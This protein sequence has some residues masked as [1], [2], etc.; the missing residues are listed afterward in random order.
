MS[1][2]FKTGS[3]AKAFNASCYLKYNALSGT[4]PGEFGT[5]FVAPSTWY[6]TQF[7]TMY[8]VDP[9]P[10]EGLSIVIPDAN[11]NNVGKTLSFRKPRLTSDVSP[12]MLSTPGGQNVGPTSA[13]VLYSPG[14]SCQIV[15]NPFEFAN[16]KGYKWRQSWEKAVDNNI[17]YVDKNLN[18]GFTSVAQAL[19]A[20]GTR[21]EYT[22][23]YVIRVGSGVFFEDTMQVPSYVSIIGVSPVNTTIVSKN[24]NDIFQLEG[25][26]EISQMTL[27]GATNFMQAAIRY[28]EEDAPHGQAVLDNC[29]LINNYHAFC[30]IN[31][32]QPST[33]Y[34]K[35]CEIY[36]TYVT[37][38]HI[39]SNDGYII[40]HID[41]LNVAMMSGDIV[42]QSVF[43]AMGSATQIDIYNTQIRNEFTQ[44][45][46]NAG[47]TFYDGAN[48]RAFNT[49]FEN[50]GV[51]I[52]GAYLG[53][54]SLIECSN[55]TI[56]GALVP[57]VIDHP[58]NI[59]SI[60][61]VFT[62]TISNVSPYMTFS[63][64]VPGGGRK[65]VIGGILYQRD[66]VT[67]PLIPISTLLRD[68]V[69]LGIISGGN[70]LQNDTL[71]VGVS[72]GMGYI[73]NTD[74]NT[75]DRVFWSD[76]IIPLSINSINYIVY[77]PISQVI[78]SIASRPDLVNEILFGR[79]VVGNSSI[80]H[81]EDQSLNILH[82]VTKNQEALRN[83]LG[84]IYSYGSN[85]TDNGNLTLNTSKGSYYYGFNEYILSGGSNIV[86]DTYFTDA[87][88]NYTEYAQDMAVIDN[89]N[90]NNVAGGVLSA[91]NTGYWTKH[92]I[93]ALG[94]IA[95]EYFMLYGNSQH[96][97]S[98]D[99]IGSTLPITPTF[100]DEMFVPIASLT[101][102]Q[103]SSAI[104]IADIRPRIGAIEILSSQ[105]TGSGVTVHAALQGLLADDHPQYLL[106]NGTRSMA[107]SLD[108][109][110][111]SITNIN[112]I[113]GIDAKHHASRHLPGG[114]D[115]ETFGPPSTIGTSNQ[116]GV[117]PAF[118]QQDHIHDH[119][120][121]SR[122]DMHALVTTNTHGFM[123]S[124]DKN[125]LTVL[126]ITSAANADVDTVV[127]SNSAN[128]ISDYNT[129][130]ALSAGWVGGNNVF[131][132]V[133]ANSAL[134]MSDNSTVNN[135]SAGWELT[136]TAVNTN[137]ASWTS[138]DSVYSTVN[139]TSALWTAD[140][141]VVVT[142]SATWNND[143]NT[144]NALS[145]SW[146]GGNSVYSTVNTTSALW[147]ADYNSMNSLSAG[148]E[149][150]RTTVNTTSATW[151]NDHNTLNTLSGSWTGGNSAFSTVNA[152]SALWVADYNSM[153]SLSGGWELARTTINSTSATWNNDHNTL[154]SL[155]AGWVA[156]YNT[157]NSLSA[158]WAGAQTVVNT[159]SATW[160]NDHNTVNSL[161]ADWAGAQ[162]VVN[163]TSAAW[164]NDHN[165]IN[166][167]SAGWVGG[168]S[169]FTTVNA[170]SALWAADY[171]IT[172]ASSAAWNAATSVVNTTSATW[173]NTRNTVNSLSAG[174]TGGN[175]AF[176]TVNANSAS[177][178]ADYNSMN[179]LSGGWELARTTVNTNSASW[180]PITSQNYVFAYDTNTK[181][182]TTLLSWTGITYGTDQYINGWTHT[183]G[184]SSFFCNQ[185]GLYQI[186]FAGCVFPASNARTIEIRGLYNGA[187][188]TGSGCQALGTTSLRVNETCHFMVSAVSGSV[189]AMQ[190]AV[191]HADARLFA[192][193]SIMTPATILPSTTLKIARIA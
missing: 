153:N 187:A 173:N 44:G 77:N 51:G 122:S 166:S 60:Q 84:A 81:I 53:A 178:V 111:N 72:A 6:L 11:A 20:V 148:W 182:T 30:S 76:A 110:G 102:Q 144:L 103:G 168:N 165:T 64:I 128:W 58:G 56:E 161:S 32:A 143:H 89:A 113:D 39:Q 15:A 189:I 138:A 114:P 188:I 169:A 45:S 181:S 61:G 68:T 73:F 13:Y 54:P 119:G 83:G 164:N 70:I 176:S 38:I 37:P 96:A 105:G 63:F 36:G 186:D 59:G 142:T 141:T 175:S 126:M 46:I 43:M 69:G 52:S 28:E 41:R 80:D 160:N 55:M 57:I 172:N 183:A 75:I 112:L 152:N 117:Q 155:S 71:K 31:P 147:V 162:T 27:S 140:N 151:N 4:K 145:G 130:N 190:F 29:I 33:L 136:R 50:V 12:I 180:A 123:A 170:N 101:I 107:G 65:N 149:L 5:T 109:G 158:D 99:A 100:M 192:P 22:T 67:Q 146:T 120:V 115:A 92:A 139:T 24:G 3:K 34:C 91:L 85:V 94:G 16:N 154:N 129:T 26:T 191:S 133:N 121:Q 163:T 35:D 48:I 47:I 88:G 62:D 185:T 2:S 159:T 79:V 118:A 66:L 8:Y 171:T 174:W 125:A 135:L 95:E 9:T 134:W 131:S 177:W 184:T 137:S 132:T 157:V 193:T 1:S 42:S 21:S 78:E 19:S 108:L 124:S 106:V 14:E 10:G 25:S 86:F 49:F 23:P 104:R 150:S 127:Y 18:N 82:G 74:I 179:S 98:A 90:Y 87:S 167:L 97:L 40:C 156:D 7:E 93:Y 17:L 116:Q